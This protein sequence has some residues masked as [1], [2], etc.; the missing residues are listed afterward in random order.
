MSQ[1]IRNVYGA[2]CKSDPAHLAGRKLIALA[3]KTKKL[4]VE[5]AD[6]DRRGRGSALNYDIYD[7]S[8]SGGTAVIQRR[9]TTVSKY[10]QSPH[11]D[12]YLIQKKGRGIIVTDL[13]DIKHLVVRKAKKLDKHKLIDFIIERDRQL[14]AETAV[15][16]NMSLIAKS[17]S[18]E[19]KSNRA[20]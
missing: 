6:F 8:K 20:I 14:I 5:S 11:K 9:V 7:I 2:I 10:G 4:D 13:D 17:A 16:A 3:I 1:F 18:S 12:Y 19:R 15:T